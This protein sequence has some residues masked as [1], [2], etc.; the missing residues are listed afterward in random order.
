MELNKDTFKIYAARAYQND[1]CTGMPEFVSD[2]KVFDKIIR[3]L[4]KWQKGKDIDIRLLVNHFI[5]ARNNFDIHCVVKMMM[6][7][8]TDTVESEVK[9]VLHYLKML[10]S[11]D[12]TIYNVN[13]D[14]RLAGSLA[15]ELT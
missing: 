15:K 7:K 11:K 1:L 14:M 6:F 10:T 5:F 3:M 8:A 13:L 12:S 2:L 9:T 4:K